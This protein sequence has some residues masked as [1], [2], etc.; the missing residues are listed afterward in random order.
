MPELPDL[1]VYARNLEKQLSNKEVTKVVVYTPGKLNA[2]QKEINDA[3][4]SLKVVKFKRS[5]KEMCIEFEDGKSV[6]VHLMLE[7]RFDIVADVGTVAFKMLAFG[8][9][10]VYLVISDPTGWAKME[11]NPRDADAPD[12]LS[13][14]FSLDYFKRNLEERKLKNI[15]AFLIDQHIVRGIGNA[16]VDEILWDAKISPQSKAGKL[17]GEAV[18][19]LHRSIRTVLLRSVDEIMQINPNIINGEVRDFMRVH[20]KG[21]RVCPNGFSI[22]TKKIASKT[23]Y[24]TAEQVVYE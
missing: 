14:A 9:N 21:K 8:F 23:T 13:P 15:K 6:C 18:E 19:R 5:G 4:I 12:A 20:H 1:E 16:Y 2:T 22:Q 10:G 24:Y 11:L 3:L 7:G 17:P